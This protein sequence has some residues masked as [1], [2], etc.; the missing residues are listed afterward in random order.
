MLL[1]QD[2]KTTSYRETMHKGSLQGGTGRGCI[3]RV[4]TITIRVNSVA[5]GN[6]PRHRDLVTFSIKLLKWSL[7]MF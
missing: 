3:Y 6:A 5:T 1:C 2:N 7:D 4:G